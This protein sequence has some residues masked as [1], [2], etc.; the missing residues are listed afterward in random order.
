MKYHSVCDREPVSPAI[1]L[2]GYMGQIFLCEVGCILWT[3]TLIRCSV[4][5]RVPTVLVLG[6][7][8]YV[9]NYH[10]LYSRPRETPLIF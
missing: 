7:E 10:I 5:D 3:G 1:H 6:P 8:D 9:E 2:W 4:H